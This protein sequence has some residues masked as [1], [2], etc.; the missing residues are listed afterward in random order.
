VPASACVAS[1]LLHLLSV[2]SFSHSFFSLLLPPPPP[3]PT[4]FPYT[5]LFRSRGHLIQELL[6]SG[7]LGHTIRIGDI[8]AARHDVLRSLAS[9]FRA[10]STPQRRGASFPQPLTP[11]GAG[12]GTR[13]ICQ[14]RDREARVHDEQ[15][16]ER[17]E[18]GRQGRR[19]VVATEHDIV[20]AD[21]PAVAALGVR[22]GHRERH[23]VLAAHLDVPEHTGLHVGQQ[24]ISAGLLLALTARLTGQTGP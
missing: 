14:G 22:A 15:V 4:L 3:R 23:G 7:T 5:T 17:V 19:L 1:P 16:I 12:D 24:E 18:R 9:T 11:V 20:G 21:A 10:I 8:P 6:V 2:S 13:L